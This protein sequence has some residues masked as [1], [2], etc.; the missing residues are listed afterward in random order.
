MKLERVE[1]REN[2]RDGYQF[3]VCGVIA[4]SEL[5]NIKDVVAVHLG[6][7]GNVSHFDI[8]E[9]DNGK[10]ALYSMEYNGYVPDDE[11]MTARFPRES[12]RGEALSLWV[13]IDNEDSLLDPKKWIEEA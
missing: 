8:T 5:A 7:D 9:T 4:P 10:L 11:F 2:G 1:R 3:E 13:E 6:R 12:S